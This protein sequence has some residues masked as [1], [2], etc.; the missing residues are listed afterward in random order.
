MTISSLQTSFKPTDLLKIND[1]Q[2]AYSKFEVE[3]GGDKR[4]ELTDWTHTR[5]VSFI[6][7][8]TMYIP[9]PPSPALYEVYFNK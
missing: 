2:Q 3:G 1:N 8:D 9:H 4:N 5:I 6:V 7:L